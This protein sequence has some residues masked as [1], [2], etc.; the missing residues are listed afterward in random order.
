[1]KKRNSEVESMFGIQPSDREPIVSHNNASSL[2]EYEYEYLKKELNSFYSRKQP[3]YSLPNNNSQIKWNKPQVTRSKEELYAQL[4]FYD[5]VKTKEK[6]TIAQLDEINRE[7]KQ[8]YS[9]LLQIDGYEYFLKHGHEKLRIDKLNKWEDP[10]NIRF[11]QREMD[12]IY[13]NTINEYVN[14]VMPIEKWWIV[15]DDLN[16]HKGSNDPQKQ[17]VDIEAKKQLSSYD[18]EPIEI[19]KNEDR[20]NFVVER[21]DPTYFS[22]NI[23]DI[24]KI[25]KERG[26]QSSKKNNKSLFSIFSKKSK[27]NAKQIDVSNTNSVDTKKDNIIEDDNSKNV[28][29]HQTINQPQNNNIPPQS[30]YYSQ[31]SVSGVIN[32]QQSSNNMLNNGVS[33]NFVNNQTQRNIPP[34]PPRTNF[35]N[36]G[37]ASNFQKPSINNQYQNMQQKPQN[38]QFFD[39]QK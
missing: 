33:S 22:P 30:N 28:V 17:F 10:R 15:E 29:A 20:E 24:E 1:M 34:I 31:Q 7:V 12:I 13:D 21:D 18:V 37:V 38:K 26:D 39:Y 14:I 36:Q 16:K 19:I 3:Y 25:G 11:Y 2:T 27:N 8:I 4:K 32:N 23:P 6:L 5:V 9:E 35:P